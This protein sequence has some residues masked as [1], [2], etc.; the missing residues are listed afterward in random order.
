MG[1]RNLR[2]NDH[3]FSSYETKAIWHTLYHN[4]QF[5]FYFK[6]RIRYYSKLLLVTMKSPWH[7]LH[8]VEVT[9]LPRSRSRSLGKCYFAP[10]IKCD[11]ST[12]FQLSRN[13]AELMFF[14]AKCF[15]VCENEFEGADT[16]IA[17]YCSCLPFT[18]LK[19]IYKRFAYSAPAIIAF[20]KS[21]L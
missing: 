19:S 17:T 8:Y 7:N 18:A 5:G 11:R 14:T 6:S 10:E 13:N 4:G 20:V 3:L 16:S 15:C 9:Y 2:Y 12:K 1:N 21:Q